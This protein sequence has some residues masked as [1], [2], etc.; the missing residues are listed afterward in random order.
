MGCVQDSSTL[1]FDFMPISS[2]K[3]EHP[4]M[5]GL[6]SNVETVTVLDTQS[7]QGLHGCEEVYHIQTVD[8]GIEDVDRT[9]L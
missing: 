4:L 9:E 7:A 3:S 5:A 8:N 6:P 1:E 2:R